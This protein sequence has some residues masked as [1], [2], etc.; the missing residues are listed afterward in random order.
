M[1]LEHDL[2]VGDGRI[3][4]AYDTGAGDFAV[5]WHHGTP[6]TGALL[7]PLLEAAGERDIRLFSFGRPSYGG[8]TG[9]P[10]RRVGSVADDVA[11]LC[12]ALGIDRF[13]TMG[14]S[15]GG[16]HALA[17]AALLPG[18]VSG[19]ACLA[20]IAPLTDDFDWFAGMHSGAALRSAMHGRDARARFQETAEFDAGSFVAA[21]WAILEGEWAS[22]GEDAGRASAAG[23]DGEIDDD[24]AY[25]S[26]W[27]FDLAQVDVPVLL[28]QGGLDRIV[29]PSH[30]EW[31][32]R[33]LPD[34]ELRLRPHDGHVSVLAACGEAMDWLVDR[35]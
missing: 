9:L 21:D 24:V 1:I 31:M 27:G 28:L 17:C 12:D 34:A 4:H 16:P 26:L 35:A 7:E 19:V 8:S 20:G 25:V 23:S 15:G 29:P 18:R 30:A 11:Q 22:L 13:A 32:S 14:A 2:A 33:Q 5:L 10:G 3:I 6:Q